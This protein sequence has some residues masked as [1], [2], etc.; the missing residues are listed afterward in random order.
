[1]PELDEEDP[2]KTSKNE[3][4]QETIFPSAAGGYNNILSL[5]KDASAML[6]LEKKPDDPPPEAA[7]PPWRKRSNDSASEGATAATKAKSASPREEG[8]TSKAGPP[9]KNM[10]SRGPPPLAKSSVP[11]QVPPPPPRKRPDPWGSVRAE[12]DRDTSEAERNRQA[13]HQAQRA[14]CSAKRSATATSSKEQT[15]ER[16][17]DQWNM[18]EIKGRVSARAVATATPDVL[19][20]RESI[21]FL[22]GA[23]AAEVMKSKRTRRLHVMLE[24]PHEAAPLFHQDWTS[25]AGS[26]SDPL[27]RELELRLRDTRNRLIRESLVEGRSVFY[28]SSESSMWPLVQPDDA[29]TFQPIQAAT[30]KDGIHAFQKK[31]PEIGVGDIVFCQVQ[32]SQQY[33]AHIVLSVEQSI[34]HTEPMYGIGNIQR[35]FNGWCLREHIFGILVDVQVWWDGQYYSRPEPKTVFAQVQELVKEHSWNRAAA[36]LCEPRWEAHSSGSR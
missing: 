29:C 30:A 19:A 34:H 16:S 11:W 31:A 15:A 3:S 7:T 2:S 17:R 32:R 25:V 36:K 27:K 10:T 18:A 33:N 23:E 6:Q 35:H 24:G 13:H 9:A 26:K 8:L 28:R 1:M 4:V 5:Q 20:R 21:A 22:N 14:R 12:M